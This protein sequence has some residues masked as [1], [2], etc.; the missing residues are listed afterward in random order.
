[1]SRGKQKCGMKKKARMRVTFSSD[2]KTQRY[3]S[4][5]VKRNSWRR[6]DKDA[7][8]ARQC[9]FYQILDEQRNINHVVLFAV[10][11]S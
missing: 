8:P 6:T 2:A 5:Q 10:E 7:R 4:W 9:A 3:H 11:E 1:M